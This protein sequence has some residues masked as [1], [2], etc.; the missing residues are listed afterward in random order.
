MHIRDGKRVKGM[1]SNR[2]EWKNGGERKQQH[3]EKDGK[4]ENRINKSDGVRKKR[5]QRWGAIRVEL[6][7]LHC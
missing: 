7:S 4:R 5:Q 2:K 6:I 1:I 3:R